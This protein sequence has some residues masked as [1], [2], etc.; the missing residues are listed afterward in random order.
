MLYYL[1]PTSSPGVRVSLLP[2]GRVHEVCVCLHLRVSKIPS[3]PQA[4]CVRV[5]VML[6]I[7][8]NAD[9]CPLP[10]DCPLGQRS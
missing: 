5:K 10:A 1:K 3:R 6:V 2:M 7:E 9:I 4:V 8:A